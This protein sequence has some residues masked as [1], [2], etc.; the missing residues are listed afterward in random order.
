[1]FYLYD[2]A[3][4]IPEVI[5]I[6]NQNTPWE[7]IS[8]DSRTIQERALFIALKGEKHDGHDFIKVACQKG[9]AGVVVEKRYYQEHPL[10]SKELPKPIL[11]VDN[12]I[13]ALQ[14]WAKY[15]HSLFRPFNICVTGSNGKTTTK[16]MIVQLLAN[17][18]HVLKSKGN[19]NNE[20]GVP[21]TILDLASDHDVLVMEMAARKSGEIKELT[22]I[23]RPD[24][25]VIT[26]IGEAHLGL[27]ESKDNI[28]REK[29]ELILALKD[30]GTAII[31]RDDAYFDYL[32][33]CIS[34]HNEIIS[35]GFHPKAQIRALN[36]WQKNEQELY[37]ELLLSGKDKFQVFLPL[38]GKFNVSN[39][40]AA[41]AVAIKMN[42]P[43]KE[44]INSLSYFKGTNLRMEYLVLDKGITLIQ[45]Y[46][47]ANPTATKEALQS[48]AS[49]A[50]GRFK[51]ALLGDM[52]ELGDS[53]IYYHKEVGHLA[54]ALSY[55]I[56]IAYGDYGD[57]IIQGAQEEGMRKDKIY[58]FRK[59]EKEQLVYWLVQSVPEH[60]IILLK[61]SRDMRMEDI[62]QYWKIISK[63]KESAY[64]A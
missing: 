29:S 15:Y 1:M 31:N 10:L 8:I 59:E 56:L 55:D 28:A 19:Y 30:K 2:W 57:F 12:T 3:K 53:S 32:S 50:E 18:Y 39:A 36:F 33:N 58:Y 49:I 64:H 35:F 6:G 20:I 27:F 14:L 37:F 40:L 4:I 13:Q 22:S 23:V 46:Y 47:N 61:G 5:I 38:L 7:H 26:N 25:A 45:D 24:I 9:A 54:A 63:G 11:V 51:I 62:V 44:I 34:D 16:E 43:I 52:L 48:V 17:K 42:I 21:L 41:I 60:S